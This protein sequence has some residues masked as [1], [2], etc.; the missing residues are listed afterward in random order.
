MNSPTET[1]VDIVLEVLGNSHGK[2]CNEVLS[3]VVICQHEVNC[4]GLNFSPDFQNREE[5]SKGSFTKVVVQH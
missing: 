4:F 3:K 1:A 2:I 5:L